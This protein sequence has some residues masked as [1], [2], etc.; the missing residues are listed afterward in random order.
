MKFCI[1][2]SPP[3]PFLRKYRHGGQMLVMRCS[4]QL[5]TEYSVIIRFCHVIS[6][7]PISYSVVPLSF[8]FALRN[9][10]GQACSTPEQTSV[11]RTAQF[12]SSVGWCHTVPLIYHRGRIL[13]RCSPYGVLCGRGGI[14]TVSVPTTPNCKLK[15]NGS[16]R[17]PRCS[18]AIKNCWSRAILLN[19][20][21]SRHDMGGFSPP[22]RTKTMAAESF[23][24]SSKQYSVKN[25]P[26]GHHR[27]I[28]CTGY[29]SLP[30]CSDCIC[31]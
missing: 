8:L 24:Q 20:L 25:L 28:H 6:K 5:M 11:T 29:A 30:F 2:P 7:V 3:V 21:Q 17:F 16:S 26:I 13:S 18:L 23:N 9:T 4:N 27:R 19:K 1:T 31:S 14:C 22:V 15:P 12:P 10:A